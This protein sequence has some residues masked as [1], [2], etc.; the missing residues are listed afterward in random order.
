MLTR[1]EKAVQAEYSL[2]FK[3]YREAQ[4]L[5]LKR[6]PLAMIFYVLGCWGPSILGLL[7]IAVYLFGLGLGDSEDAARVLRNISPFIVGCMILLPLRWWNLWRAYAA[8]FPKG[9]RQTIFSFDNEQFISAIPNRSEARVYWS[10]LEKY[11]EDGKQ[12]L[13]FPARKR[14]FIIPSEPCRRLAGWPCAL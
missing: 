1:E 6:S 14:F 7:L 9:N 4:W 12:M 10:A 11:E 3:D 8:M 13:L 5:Y 2:S